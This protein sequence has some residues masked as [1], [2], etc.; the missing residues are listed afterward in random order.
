MKE[1][2]QEKTKLHPRNQHRERYDLKALI[3]VCP[4]LEAF[5]TTNIYNSETIDFF[6]PEAVKMLNKALLKH[7][8]NVADWDIPEGYLCPPIPGRADYIHHLADLLRSSNY[9]KIPTGEKITCLDIGVGA[10]CVYPLIGVHEYGWKFIGS[11]IDPVALAAAEK[12]IAANPPLQG[13]ITCRLQTDPNDI[14]Y[15]I[16]QKEERI[17]CV[18][19]NPPFHASPEEAHAS[20]VKKVSNLKGKL[21]EKPVLNFGG[22]SRELW[23]A[24]GEERFIQNMIKQSRQFANSCFWFSTLVSKKA[25]LD[26]IYDALARIQAVEVKTIP[27]GQGNKISR[28]VAWTLLS[29]EEQQ[30]W[31]NTRWQEKKV[32]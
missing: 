23:C 9:G 27:M 2:A 31:K 29:K 18:V 17:D 5:V 6:N 28:V 11:D 20:A 25:N 15:R 26:R 32:D 30:V 8:Y 12:I 16:I 19:C 14:F 10:N 24:G 22:Q 13:K 1:Q 3:A 7:H 21:V 4:E